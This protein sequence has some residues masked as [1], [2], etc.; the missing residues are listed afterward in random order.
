[1]PKTGHEFLLQ[2]LSGFDHLGHEVTI[3]HQQLVGVVAF[4]F[5]DMGVLDV[6]V[7]AGSLDIV[8]G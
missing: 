7:I 4:Q 2:R 8:P 1:L 3:F 5:A 6:E